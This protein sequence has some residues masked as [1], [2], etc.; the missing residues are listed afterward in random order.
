MKITDTISV[1]PGKTA[2]GHVDKASSSVLRSHIIGTESSSHSGDL[3]KL[4]FPTLGS[5]VTEYKKYDVPLRTIFSTILIITGITLL[6]MPTGM[7]SVGFAIATLCFGA[8]L[9]VGLLTRPVMLGAS[10]FYCVCG[11]LALRAGTADVSVFSL[12]FGCLI[13]AIMGAG[14]YSCDTLIRKGIKSHNRK[15]ENKRKE[16]CLG[17]KAFHHARI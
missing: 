7:H 2:L 8:M 13:F 15:L 16:E 12:M 3:I 4:M 10:I 17:Y 5:G 14:K 6:T 11:A 1:N 9:G